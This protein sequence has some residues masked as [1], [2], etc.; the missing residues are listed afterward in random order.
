MTETVA[1]RSFT[2]RMWYENGVPRSEMRANNMDPGHIV[3]QLEATIQQ[4]IRQSTHTGDLAQPLVT[5]KNPEF[6]V[7]RMP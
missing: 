3:L 7:R 6:K 4:I 2:L 5:M 1:D